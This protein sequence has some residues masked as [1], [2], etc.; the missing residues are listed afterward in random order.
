MADDTEL[1]LKRLGTV[2]K[3]GQAPGFKSWTPPE[4][5]GRSVNKDI[6]D[7][8]EASAQATSGQASTVTAKSLEEITR[9]AYEEGFTQGKENGHKEGL[10]IE[11]EKASQLDHVI[12]ALKSKSEQFDELI[13][14]Q[15]VEMTISIARHVI[16]RELSTNPEE[17]VAVIREAMALMPDSVANLTI[18]LHPEDAALV[19]DIYDLNGEST[20]SWK[21]FEDPGI[22]R[23]GCILT[24]DTAE[25]NAE[26][27][28]RI[29]MIVT[30]LL[31]GVRSDD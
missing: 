14:Q 9:Q 10:A 20:M 2:I 24:S 30:Q 12:Q 17:I 11:Q 21:I 15:L 29:Q 22:Q 6:I 8:K 3:S 18:K 4:V 25:I 19:R 5:T 31:G 23:G 27:D 1:K 26:L 7:A 16:R 28:K 13:T